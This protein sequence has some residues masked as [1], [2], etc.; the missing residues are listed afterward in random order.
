MIGAV[1][2]KLGIIET[3]A[4]IFR[5]G[6]PTGIEVTTTFKF[7]RQAD[8]FGYMLLVDVKRTIEGT[9]KQSKAGNYC[10]L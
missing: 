10:R 8:W 3:M 6:Q 7:G 2:E 5:I 4:L 1:A 9:T